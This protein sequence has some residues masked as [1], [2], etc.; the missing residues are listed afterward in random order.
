[1]GQC[2]C[3]EDREDMTGYIPYGR[4]DITDDDI[5]AVVET[6]KSDFLTQGPAVEAFEKEIVG[7]T[8]ARHAVAVNSA[9]SA[10]HIACLA[11]GLGRGDRLWS[12]PISFVAST[13]CGLYCGAQVDFVDIDPITLNISVSELRSKLQSA[14]VDGTLPKVLVVVHLTGLPCQMAEIYELARRYGVHVIEDASH[15]IGARYQGEP[16]GRC[17]YSDI[18]VFSFHPVKIMTTAEGGA[19]LTNNPELSRRMQRLRS[20][21]ITREFDEMNGASDGP[22]YYQQLELGF[23]YRLTDIQA[24][25]GLSQLKRVDHYVAKRHEIAD[26]YDRCFS[27]LPI[28]TPVRPDYCYSSFHLYV[29]QL[30]T[31]NNKLNRLQVFDALRSKNIGVNVH[32]IPIHLQPFY[33]N[34]GFNPGD[35]PAAEDYYRRAISIPIFPTLQVAEQEFVVQAITEALQG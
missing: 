12:S 33:R 7:Y 27:D 14:E 8:G 22:W 35:F 29:I 13:N 21:G 15:A 25:L 4:Q 10:L 31:R 19:A 3:R 6:L 11:L 2:K 30:D 9:T 16:V 26:I 24:A 1:M 34:L 28:T 23:N 20:H 32:Y 18:A 17:S 5:K